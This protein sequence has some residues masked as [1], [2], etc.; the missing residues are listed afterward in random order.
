MTPSPGTSARDVLAALIGAP[1]VLGLLLMGDHVNVR[2]DDAEL[3][4]ADVAAW[5]IQHGI[6][7][8]EVCRIEPSI[9]DVFVAL[10]GS[11]GKA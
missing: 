7:N 9:E 10:V 5:L 8:A 3:R 6:V 2:V 1:C 4:R 11:Q